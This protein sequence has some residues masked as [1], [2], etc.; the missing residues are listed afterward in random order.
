MKVLFLTADGVE[1]SELIVPLYR[2]KEAGLD[3][4]VA[5]PEKGPVTGKHGISTPA[6]LAFKDVKP[7]QYDLLVLPGGKGP[8]TV[9]LDGDALGAVKKIV[10]AGKPVAAICHG[11]QVL[12]SAGLLKGKSGTCWP[13]VKDDFI[14]AGGDWQDREVVVDGQL[15]TSRCPDDLPAFC[16]AIV[17]AIGKA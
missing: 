15:I 9:R 1:D 17:Q 4:D 16:G 8:E 10:A 3:V 5:G 12:I 11:A 2:L 7:E 6:N 14:A 13:G